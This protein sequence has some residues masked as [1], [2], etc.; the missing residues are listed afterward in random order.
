MTEKMEQSLI[1][2]KPDAIQ[3]GLIGKII[4]RFEDKGLKISAMKMMHWEDAL[5]DEHYA[6]LTD[7][8]FYPGI[9]K[10]MQSAPVIVMVISGIGAIAAIRT[11]VG[12][13]KGFEAS[14]GTIRGDF[15]MSTQSNSV[16]ASDSPES[17]IDEIKRFFT[18]EEV[19]D[20]SK[21]GE[22]IVFSEHFE[23]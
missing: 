2:I 15:S 22:N 18:K 20:Y 9:K 10:F 17:A 1:I 3:R 19:L 13:T 11:I 7:K 21:L 14:A 16:H 5:L 12:P 6:H 4:T 23:D 8:P